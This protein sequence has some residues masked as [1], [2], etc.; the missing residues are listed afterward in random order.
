M[1]C[2]SATEEIARLRS[3]ICKENAFGT[4]SIDACSSVVAR[5]RSHKCLRDAGSC[6]PPTNDLNSRSQASV[7]RSNGT[8][9]APVLSSNVGFAI[10]RKSLR[11]PLS[12]HPPNCCSPDCLARCTVDHYPRCGSLSRNR[13]GLANGSKRRRSIS[14][15]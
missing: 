9:A 14:N 4:G 11:A 13:R 6:C 5:D 8:C 10:P 7:P 2:R 12:G 3:F 15:H 1:Q